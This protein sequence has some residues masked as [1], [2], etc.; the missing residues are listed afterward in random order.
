ML[1]EGETVFTTWKSY[2]M[3]WLLGRFEKL[4]FTATME[5]T[6]EYRMRGLVRAFQKYWGLELDFEAMWNAVP[7]SFILDYFTTLGRSI[8]NMERDKNV[9]LAYS[10]YSESLLRTKTIGY[11]ATKPTYLRPCCSAYKVY[12]DTD[13]GYA[14]SNSGVLLTDSARVPLSGYMSS[15]YRRRVCLPNKGTALPFFKKP[16]STQGLTMAA[17]IRSIF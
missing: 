1:Q 7:F 10:Q 11:V 15:N 2:V 12:V 3:D 5:Y 4:E 16:T 9:N 6:Y 14:T 13:K 17:L 8:H